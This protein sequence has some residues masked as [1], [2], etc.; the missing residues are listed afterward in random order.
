[1]L[2]PVPVFEDTKSINI[3]KAHEIAISKK[4]SFTFQALFTKVFHLYPKAPSSVPLSFLEVPT[5][6]RNS[7]PHDMV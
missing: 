2:Y 7:F 1:M 3:L 4:F 6:C 5:N